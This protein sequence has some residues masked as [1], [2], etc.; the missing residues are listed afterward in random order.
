MRSFIL[1]LIHICPTS[2]FLLER[3]DSYISKDGPDS[4]TG[5]IFYSEPPLHVALC[6]HES[7]SES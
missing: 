7:I 2:E 4:I 3:K 5:N 1:T 6:I